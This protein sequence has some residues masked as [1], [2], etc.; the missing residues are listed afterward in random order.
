MLKHR[1]SDKGR[2]RPVM[3]SLNQAFQLSRL[4]HG[5]HIGF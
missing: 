3:A 2:L 5:P 1:L 4:R